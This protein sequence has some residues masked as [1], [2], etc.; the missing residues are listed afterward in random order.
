MTTEYI[1]LLTPTKGTIGD[2]FDMNHKYSYW[3]N[4]KTART[5]LDNAKSA[6][7]ANTSNTASILFRN[8]HKF[9][10]GLDPSQIGIDEAL[11]EMSDIAEEIPEVDDFF[12]SNNWQN[13]TDGWG[14][15][16]W[17]DTTWV[18]T[19]N[20]DQ[21]DT[22]NWFYPGDYVL[23]AWKGKERGGQVATIGPLTTVLQDA[24]SE[25]VREVASTD[26]IRI[27][28]EAEYLQ[29]ILQGSSARVLFERMQLLLDR[30]GDRDPPVDRQIRAAMNSPTLTEATVKYYE[31][32]V[33]ELLGV[34][35]TDDDGTGTSPK[36][37]VSEAGTEPPR[38]QVPPQTDPVDHTTPVQIPE[39][40][41]TIETVQYIKS[42]WP[43]MQISGSTP[44]PPPPDPTP[45]QE[46]DELSGFNQFRRLMQDGGDEGGAKTMEYFFDKFNRERDAL[47][48]GGAGGDSEDEQLLAE[49]EG[50]QRVGGLGPQN[51]ARRYEDIGDALLKLVDKADRL[52]KYVQVLDGE[53]PPESTMWKQDLTLLR[54][55][56]T[57]S[58]EGR[59]AVYAQAQSYLQMADQT[60]TQ[61]EDPMTRER[62]LR[63]FPATLVDFTGGEEEIVKWFEQN[64]NIRASAIEDAWKSR[65]ST[66]NNTMLV[67]GAIILLVAVFYNE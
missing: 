33:N 49:G 8:L 41:E 29:F 36:D 31:E 25:K 21:G 28:T 42:D 56:Q 18:Q 14:N 63:A 43:F 60:A 52:L 12:Q 3:F 11:S 66:E 13:T 24:K 50:G 2:K 5:M 46:T 9:P 65:P 62:L 51:L 10:L 22:A 40:Q 38:T 30:L 16:T 7:L 48:A 37:D 4:G 55:F 27:L 6:Q 19:E 67:L 23:Y 17:D 47:Q 32:Y 53:A 45:P 64:R 57:A 35:V 61:G 20:F 1:F 58:N 26:I 39:N 15:D 54:A 59:D 34:V 44:D